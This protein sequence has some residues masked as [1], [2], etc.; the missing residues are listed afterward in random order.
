MSSIMDPGSTTHLSPQQPIFSRASVCWGTVE[1]DYRRA[2]RGETIVALAA[3]DWRGAPVLFPALARDF[4]LIVPELDRPNVAPGARPP[5]AVW[6]TAFLDGL[7][8]DSVTLLA[9]ER[10]GGAAFGSAMIEPGRVARLV[11]VLDAGDTDHPLA[12]TDATLCGTGTKL[13]VT[14]LGADLESAGSEVAAALLGG[15][16][17]P[18]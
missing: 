9:D 18:G 13:Y 10:F 12:A 14:W 3:R 1:T 15:R 6:L 11:V 4:R 7:G 16:R 5:F 8:L 17:P 2:G